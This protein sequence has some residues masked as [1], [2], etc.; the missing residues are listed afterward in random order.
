MTHEENFNQD[1]D[2]VKINDSSQNCPIIIY[3]HQL[4][5]YFHTLLGNPF[6]RLNY[7]DSSTGQYCFYRTPGIINYIITYYLQQGCLL[8]EVHYP[9]EILYDE[10]VFFGFNIQIIYDIV[11]NSITIDYYIPSGNIAL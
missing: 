4:N 7:Y 6:Q 8:T 11:S 1:S 10:L 3:A 9:P 2:L 5:Q